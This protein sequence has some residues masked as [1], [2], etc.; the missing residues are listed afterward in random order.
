MYFDTAYVAKFYLNE[1]GSEEVRNLAT[2]VT[3][4][5]SSAWVIPELHSVL[6]R[7]IREGSIQ[8]ED[9]WRVTAQ[10]ASHVDSRLWSLV[11]VGD[12]AFCIERHGF[13]YP[14]HPTCSCVAATR[15]TW[16]R[17]RSLAKRKFGAM[18]G[19]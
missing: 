12:L 2:R 17:Q 14:H 5:R 1:P 19:T 7:K 9:G 10:F 3:T 6:H 18:I 4:I 16:L 13:W 8:I 15:F 11:P